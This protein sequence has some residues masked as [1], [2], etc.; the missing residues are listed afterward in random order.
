M[1]DVWRILR[2]CA[3]AESRALRTVPVRHWPDVTENAVWHRRLCQAHGRY[4]PA[5][6]TLLLEMRSTA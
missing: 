6:P 3:Y 1:T 5:A 4:V 2:A